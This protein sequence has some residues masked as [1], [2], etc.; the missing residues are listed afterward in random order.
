[1]T[2][3]PALLGATLM[4]AGLILLLKNRGFVVAC[5]FCSAG[6]CLLGWAIL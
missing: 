6:S 1:M 5:G 3:V 2:A 4:A